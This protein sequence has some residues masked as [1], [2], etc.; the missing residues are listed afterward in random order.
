[1][2]CFPYDVALPYG[3]AYIYSIQRMVG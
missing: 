3:G 1:M 2:L